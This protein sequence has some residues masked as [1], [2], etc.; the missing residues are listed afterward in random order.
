M[1]KLQSC[2]ICPVS[3]L[4]ALRAFQG[5]QPDL[6]S[7]SPTLLRRIGLQTVVGIV[8]FAFSPTEF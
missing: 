7:P 1:M 3:A 8:I 4:G 6:A 5:D 2:E